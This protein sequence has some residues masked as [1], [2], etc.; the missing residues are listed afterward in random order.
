MQD[1]Y[2]NKDWLREQYNVKG[3]KAR[4]IAAECG[5]SEAVIKKYL[6]QYGIGR[7]VPELKYW[8]SKDWL[9]QNY[10]ATDI[11]VRDLAAKIG[12]QHTQL[13]E[14]IKSTA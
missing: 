10:S 14:Y 6:Y 8:Q 11:Q 13:Y 9:I 7:K 5:V 1:I 2:R 12:V 3:K 4:E